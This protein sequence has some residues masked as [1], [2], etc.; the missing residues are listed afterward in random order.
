[1]GAKKEKFKNVFILVLFVA[2]L[3]MPVMLLGIYSKVAN[4]ENM[5]N[6]DNSKKLA[7][8]KAITENIDHYFASVIHVGGVGSDIMTVRAR[9]GN[10]FLDQDFFVHTSFNRAESVLDIGCA[11]GFNVISAGSPT[12]SDIWVEDDIGY[13]RM[14]LA[15]RINNGDSFDETENGKNIINIECEKEDAEK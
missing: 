13:A 4:L 12:N 1:M 10:D 9:Y 11:S 8:L 6:S 5:V 15:H 2:V 7:G 14:S 3:V